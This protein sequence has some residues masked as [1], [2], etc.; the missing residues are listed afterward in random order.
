MTQNPRFYFH[1]SDRSRDVLE[2]DWEGRPCETPQEAIAYAH[3]LA[4]GLVSNSKL[5]GSTLIVSDGQGR[6]I[7]AITIRVSQT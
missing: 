3:T 2:L 6:K 4:R 1:F 5:R 7:E